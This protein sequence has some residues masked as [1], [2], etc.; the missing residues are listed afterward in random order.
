MKRILPKGFLSRLT[1]L[2][3]LV[4]AIAI[5]VSG[6]AV[7]QTACFL[8]EGIG[9]VNAHVQ[10]QFN[11]IL[12][13]YL[14]IFSII[15]IVI[16]SILHYYLTKTLIKPIR[17]LIQSTKVLRKGKYPDPIT[18]DSYHEIG[19]LVEQYNSLIYQLQ[20]DDE[21]RKKLIT[22]VSH[23]LRTPLANLNGYLHALKTGVITGDQDLFES[24][25]DQS[26][27]LTE[28]LEQ[29]EQLKEYDDVS[30]QTF[31]KK[32]NINIV[33]EIQQCVLAFEWAMKQKGIDIDVHMENGHLSVYREG[34]QQVLTN[35]LDNAIQYY[36]GNGPIT[37]YGQKLK[38]H[39]YVSIGNPGITIPAEDEDHIFERFYR[40]DDSRSRETG[41]SGLG[42][43]IAKEIVE[44]HNGDIGFTAKEN[45]NVF[46]F[47]L[48]YVS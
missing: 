28:M 33:K 43:A 36:D 48:P 29:L 40:V 27:R 5:V 18:V 16:G 12:F 15:V 35:L 45:Y 23:E 38:D 39:Y 11:S 37:V 14:W 47:T 46:W 20:L 24:L 8:V 26:N 31:T 3:V 17:L 4:I 42:L 22:D 21:R 44:H 30:S 6:L 32:A 13:R 41:G 7:Y 1:F 25:Y 9:N 2:N 34:I 19:E 10:K